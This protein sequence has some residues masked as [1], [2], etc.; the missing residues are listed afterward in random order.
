LSRLPERFRAV[1]VLCDLEGRSRKDVARRLGCPEGTV[2]SRL[3]RGRELLARRLA[4]RG[5]VV[6]GGCLATILSHAAVAGVP[7]AVVASAINGATLL[8]AVK[9]AGV[10]S[11]PVATLTQGVLKAMLLNK[12]MT[13]T[14]AVLALGLVAVAG[15]SLAVGQSEGTG[16]SAAGKDAMPPGVEKAVEPGAIQKPARK[17]AEV[18]WGKEV[19]GVQ[20]GIQLGK[21]RVYQV[22]ETV[23]LTLRLR[24]NGK[25]PV[26]FRDH[27]EY[28]Y[29]NPPHITDA[30]GKAVTIQ[31]MSIFG[32]IRER[33]VAP[34]KEVDMIKLVLALRPATDREKLAAWS[35]YG[36]GEFQIQYPVKDVVGEI[37]L[38]SPGTTLTT[39]KLGLEVQEGPAGRQKPLTPE[40]A[41]RMKEGSNLTVEY[42]VASVTKAVLIKSDAKQDGWVAGHG[43]DDVCLR[44][45]YPTDRAQA[46][47]LSILTP[48]AVGQL[49]KAGV[50]DI[51]KHFG[52]KTVRVT[53]PIVKRDYR[54]RGTPVEVEIVVNDLSQL[55]VLD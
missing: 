33:S 35:L 14:V 19:D 3:A 51:E 13:T 39:G 55:G 25:E 21:N 50:R 26:P 2:A 16:Q 41:T 48:N 24:N 1:I 11:G 10:I 34:G 32:I 46:R 6:P 54:G 53:G 18:A 31:A 9:A 7:P 22:G 42:R 47:F 15:G 36:T 28:F 17:E 40:A 30:D 27:A 52:G 8:A 20:V 45:E 12:I 5:L 43:P 23:T 49:N 4:G 29:K 37:R 38:G 44:P